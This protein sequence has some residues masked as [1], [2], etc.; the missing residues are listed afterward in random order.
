MIKIVSNMIYDSLA[1]MT[2]S[3]SVPDEGY[4]R[5]VPDEGYSRNVPDE[6]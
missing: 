2:A 6:G 5:N 4:S 3:L 1:N